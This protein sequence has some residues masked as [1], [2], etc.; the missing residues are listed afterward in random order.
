MAID[1]QGGSLVMKK[2]VSGFPD[3]RTMQGMVGTG[4]GLTAALDDG[5]ESKNDT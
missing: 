3:L 5:L 2:V 1:V 4:P